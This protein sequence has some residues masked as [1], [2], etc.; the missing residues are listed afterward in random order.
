MEMSS[1][2][3]T[4]DDNDKRITLNAM[5]VKFVVK[6][7]LLNNI[8]PESRLGM[9]RNYKQL[10]SRQIQRVCDD[11]DPFKP[12]FFFMR[13]PDVLKLILNYLISGKLHVSAD[14][15]EVFVKSELSYWMLDPKKM[16]RCCKAQFEAKC[17]SKTEDINVE[18]EIIE[19]INASH[20][21][22]YSL[23]EKLWNITQFPNDIELGAYY[24]K[25]FKSSIVSIK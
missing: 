23:K 3:I 13:D 12:E 14:L 5:G 10:T 21:K 25:N 17:K 8:E 11:Y 9:L 4:S 20:F 7:S 19:K 16:S 18:E 2:K 6:E 15:C 1:A 22:T 24:S